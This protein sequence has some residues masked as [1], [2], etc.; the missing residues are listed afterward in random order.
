MVYS[1]IKNKLLIPIILVFTLISCH[2]GK[3][4]NI[5]DY[6]RY[7]NQKDNGFKTETSLDSVEVEASLKSKEYVALMDLGE[8]SLSLSSKEIDSVIRNTENFTYVYLKVKSKLEN[9]DPL[10]LLCS[11]SSE[12]DKC[13]M[14]FNNDFKEDI[15]IISN[16]KSTK[17]SI[18]ILERN[19]KLTDYFIV[20]IGF[21]LVMEDLEDKITINIKPSI[22]FDKEFSLTF[23]KFKTSQIPILDL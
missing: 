3:K 16:Q 22:A 5:S 11:D 10:T 6:I 4:L 15:E 14:Y 18:S 19:Y 1:I 12:I 23:D 21:P 8:S 13:I 7:Y 2:S 17:A 9:K 20:I